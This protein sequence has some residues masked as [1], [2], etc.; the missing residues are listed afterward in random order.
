MRARSFRLLGL[1]ALV[2][3][4]AA[5]GVK[6]DRFGST[7]GAPAAGV[8]PWY[9]V[10]FDPNTDLTQ[11]YL[12][13]G[14]AQMYLTEPMYLIVDDVHMMY[15]EAVALDDEQNVLGAAIHLATG[16]NREDY[17][18]TNNG[19]PVLV[20]DQA[21]EGESVGAPTVLRKDGVYY[22]WYAGGEGAGIGVASSDDGVNWSKYDGNPVF[23]PD[24]DWEGG[25]VAAPS[26]VLHDGRFLMYYSGGLLDDA[27]PLARRLGYEIGLAE[28]SDGMTW[29]KSGD[30]PVLKAEQSWMEG[31]V[32]SPAI[33]IDH[34]A[35]RDV[36]RLYYA[37]GIQGDP[38]MHDVAVGYAGSWDGVAFETLNDDFNPVLNEKFTITIYGL[39][40]Y[41][42]YGEAAPSVVRTGNR[43]WMAYSQTDLLGAKQGV[44]L[45]TSP[46]LKSF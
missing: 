14:D 9:K 16:P 5:C 44:A 46:M 27:P 43:Y 12:F 8:A 30:G 3:A 25:L 20:A 11:P 35:N 40:Q 26:V 45:A 22:M 41:L 37:G 2:A 18:Q 31:V 29:T 15:Y 36:Y 19:E 28:S 10:D 6:T 21:W 42:T 34:P 32:S 7:S 17:V 38:V 4:L 1:L 24:R 39:A 13:V 23:V 33:H